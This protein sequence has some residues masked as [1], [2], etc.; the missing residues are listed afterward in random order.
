MNNHI[1]GLILLSPFVWVVISIALFYILPRNKKR[2]LNALDIF[3]ILM[4]TVLI[5]AGWGALIFFNLL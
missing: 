3:P 2:D 5:L 1:W 4:A